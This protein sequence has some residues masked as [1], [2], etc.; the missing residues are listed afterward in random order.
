MT[1]DAK[2][3]GQ[4]AFERFWEK[5][6]FAGDAPS[7]WAGR[8]PI[9]QGAWQAAAEAVAAE[10]WQQGVWAGARAQEDANEYPDELVN[11]YKAST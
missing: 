9:S 6:P 7:A 2:T 1:D 10:A 5:S 8:G 3:L 11:P 4:I